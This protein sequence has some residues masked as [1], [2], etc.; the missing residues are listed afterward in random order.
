M[1][2]QKLFTSTVSPT[3]NTATQS[4]LKELVERV[5]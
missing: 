3:Q 4:W 2:D 1:P 5:E